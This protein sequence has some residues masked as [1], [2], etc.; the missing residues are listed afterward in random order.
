MR[1][2][3]QRGHDFLCA[4]L[5]QGRV[6]AGF[7]QKRFDPGG[8][9][10]EQLS[11]SCL[12]LMISYARHVIDPSGSCAVICLGCH[13]SARRPIR[14][15]CPLSSTYAVLTKGINR[16]QHIRLT[17]RIPGWIT[18]KTR[19][20]LHPVRNPQRMQRYGIESETANAF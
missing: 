19:F 20:L 10:V 1:L 6:R 7:H 12:I 15:F 4:F 17:G 14:G 9:V 5:R 2:V 3:P 8:K 16:A 13:C 18:E 11:E